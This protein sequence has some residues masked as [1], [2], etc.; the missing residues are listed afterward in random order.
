MSS[1]YS[2]ISTPYHLRVLRTHKGRGSP[3]GFGLCPTAC[4]RLP[5]R[6]LPCTC[7]GSA[8]LDP[9]A[10]PALKGARSRESSLLCC[11]RLVRVTA[12]RVRF[13]G[14]LLILALRAPVP[15]PALDSVPAPECSGSTTRSGIC[16]EAQGG[17]GGPAAQPKIHREERTS[18]SG[19]HGR[20]GE[21]MGRAC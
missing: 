7:K 10:P 9:P 14:L 16:P 5:S 18:G 2:A 11:L 15:H 20:I 3:R 1:T 19:S 8:A 17:L 4:G 6:A 12:S 21:T 13:A